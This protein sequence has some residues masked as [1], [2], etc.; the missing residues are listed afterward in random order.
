MVP[1]DMLQY[2]PIYVLLS[3]IWDFI[4]DC[5]VNLLGQPKLPLVKMP[6]LLDICLM[7]GCVCRLDLWQA[8][9]KKGNCSG[10]NNVFL[11]LRPGA[12]FKLTLLS[13]NN[14]RNNIVKNDIRKQIWTKQTIINSG[15]KGQN[16]IRMASLVSWPPVN[17][18]NFMSCNPLQTFHSCTSSPTTAFFFAL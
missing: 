7:T 5:S 16:V 13:W 17:K 10:W 2:S 12:C 18:S 8:V 9:I 6:N 11:W 14:G 4:S 3:E 1:W 15:Y